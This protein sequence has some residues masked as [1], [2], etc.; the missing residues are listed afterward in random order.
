VV[1]RFTI[2]ATRADGQKLPAQGL[3]YFCLADGKIV[4][5]DPFARPDLAQVLGMTPHS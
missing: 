5:D 2:E 1:A 4:V 3:T